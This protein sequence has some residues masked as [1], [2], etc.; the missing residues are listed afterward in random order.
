M[1]ILTILLQSDVSNAN[2]FNN[3]LMLGY[4]VMWL[5]GMVYVASQ[6][7]R[8]RNIQKDI[9]LMQQILQEDEQSG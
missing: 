8:Q 5:I 6:I 1:Y 3:Y 9:Q 2:L 7:M 4:G